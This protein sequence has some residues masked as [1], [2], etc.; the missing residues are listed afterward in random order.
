MAEEVERGA[1]G[2]E[3]GRERPGDDT[4]VIAGCDPVAVDPEPLDLD[5]GVDL[6]EGL[7]RAGAPSEH[8]FLP[9]RQRGHDPGGW[10]HQGRSDVTERPEVLG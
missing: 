2:G 1:F 6:A 3:H 7:G 9:G 10:R 4:E 8:A 5:D